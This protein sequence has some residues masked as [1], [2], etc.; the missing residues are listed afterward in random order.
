MVAPGVSVGSF[1]ATTW[2]PGTP[3]TA[4]SWNTEGAILQWLLDPPEVILRNTTPQSIAHGTT[5][6]VGFQTVVKDNYANFDGASP[7]WVVGTPTRAIVQVPGWYEFEISQAWAGATDTTRRISF[8]R[9]DGAGALR[10]RIDRK[11]C[12]SCSATAREYRSQ[13]DMFL[14]AGSYVELMLHQDSGVAVSTATGPPYTELSM[15]WV[16]FS[17]L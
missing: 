14:N 12:N 5:T 9:V 8:L 13:Y 1:A 7:H 2:R 4:A 11:N 17:G 10:G 3:V 15:R 6:A 16:S